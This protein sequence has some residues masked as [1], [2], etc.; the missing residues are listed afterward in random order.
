MQMGYM[1]F[2]GN[3]SPLHVFITKSKYRKSNILL[4]GKVSPNHSSGISLPNDALLS[5][6][7]QPT[8]MGPKQSKI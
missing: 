3:V 4:V 8:F 6:S 2:K 1:R 5:I 7:K